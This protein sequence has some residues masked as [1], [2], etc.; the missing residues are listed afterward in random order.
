MRRWE[1]AYNTPLPQREGSE[2][3]NKD[4]SSGSK[5]TQ[6]ILVSEGQEGRGFPRGPQGQCSQGSVPAC[7]LLREFKSKWP[8]SGQGDS[9]VGVEE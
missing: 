8:V 5:L 4:P 6:K 3:K 2:L 1:A 7:L 9:R